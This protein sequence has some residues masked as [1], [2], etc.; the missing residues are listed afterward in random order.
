MRVTRRSHLSRIASD[1]DWFAEPWWE[2]GAEERNE[3]RRQHHHLHGPRIASATPRAQD[4]HQGQDAP[5]I[6][7]R[8]MKGG[9]ETG[10]G[11]RRK[12]RR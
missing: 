5:F 2:D 6:D 12:G 1:D 9:K 10:A 11:K 8:I 3:Q 4:E 7:P